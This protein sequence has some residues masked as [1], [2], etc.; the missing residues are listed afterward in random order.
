MRPTVRLLT[1]G[2]LLASGCGKM[3]IDG[4]VVD[5]KGAPL[6]DVSVTAVGSPCYTRSDAA[7]KFALECQPGTHTVV[8]SAEGFTSEEFTQDASERKR[9]DSGRHLL[10]Q[11]PE[12]HGLHLFADNEYTEMRPGRLAR[13][14][15]TEGKLTHR[16]VCLDAD[17]S[18]A[19][20]LAAGTHALFD[21]EHP[22]WRPFKL[23]ADGCAYRDT[24]NER[25][26]WSVTYREK[27]PYEVKT[28]N[29]GKQIALM[30]LTAGDY[31]IAD[32]KGFF[33]GADQKEQK[34]SYTGYWLKVR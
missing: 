24:K 20:T 3:A 25:H 8:I 30:Q 17:K 18:E 26:Q 23:D 5:A 27:A 21:F 29:E 19:N 22:G 7:G 6:A 15:A 31:F 12:K 28:I 16:A 10:I 13:S 11:V 32:W 33:V 34:Y 4:E 2:T 14:L 1:M 9:Y